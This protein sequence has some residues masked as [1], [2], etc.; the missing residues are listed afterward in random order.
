MET[1]NQKTAVQKTKCFDSFPNQTRSSTPD[2]QTSTIYC[3]PTIESTLSANMLEL[4]LVE[5]LCNTLFSII[6]LLII[7]SSFLFG[8]PNHSV[9]VLWGLGY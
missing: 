6:S 7:P 4:F 8:L 2:L 9:P 1:N 5:V 3:P